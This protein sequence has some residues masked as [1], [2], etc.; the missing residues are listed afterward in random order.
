[1][2][3]GEV[4]VHVCV[5]GCLHIVHCVYMACCMG[6]FKGKAVRTFVFTLHSMLHCG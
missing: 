5:Y 4:H 3:Q 6:D 1:M 2:L